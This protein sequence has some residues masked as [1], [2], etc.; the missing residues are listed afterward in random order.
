MDGNRDYLCHSGN[1]ESKMVGDENEGDTISEYGDK[2][3]SSLIVK[4]TPKIAPIQKRITRQCGSE[5]HEIL[6]YD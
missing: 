3:Y 4:A 5:H 1:D 2:P 6:E